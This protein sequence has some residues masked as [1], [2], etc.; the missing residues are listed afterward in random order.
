MRMFERESLFGDRRHADQ[1]LVARR[2]MQGLAG[3]LEQITPWL[4]EVGSWIF[5]GLI[6]LN[7]VVIA[8][9]ITVAALSIALTVTGITAALWH[10]A[11]WVAEA[12]VA[13]VILSAFVLLLVMA[14]AMPPESE[15][16]KELKREY[17]EQR[18]RH[19][20]ERRATKNASQ[21]N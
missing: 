10:M 21:P 6:A 8:A 9:L 12:F 5:G 1:A 4:L 2:A 16:E 11:P 15:A 20:L 18:V 7:L 3:L 13:T 14:H 17:R 19:K